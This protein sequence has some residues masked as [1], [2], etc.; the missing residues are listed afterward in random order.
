VTTQGPFVLYSAT[1]GDQGFNILWLTGDGL[2]QY[3]WDI[4]APITT[5][6]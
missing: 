1:A 6:G 3:S 4:R 2:I 5:G